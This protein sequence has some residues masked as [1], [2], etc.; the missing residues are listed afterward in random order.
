MYYNYNRIKLLQFRIHISAELLLL[1]KKVIY[2]FTSFAVFCLVFRVFRPS[3]AMHLVFFACLSFL[4]RVLRHLLGNWI[5]QTSVICKFPVE[6]DSV[7]DNAT[8]CNA[9]TG[10]LSQWSG[11]VAAGMPFSVRSDTQNARTEKDGE[12]A[13]HAWIIPM[14]GARIINSLKL[15]TR[16]G[17]FIT[18]TVN[19]TN[20]KAVP[21]WPS[22]DSISLTSSSCCWAI[23]SC[24]IASPSAT[25]VWHFSDM[26]TSSLSLVREEAIFIRQK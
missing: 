25:K 2:L 23:G 4:F 24:W 14:T 10:A 1:S 20:L 7:L 19:T 17:K 8:D 12:T 5:D 3:F 22:V 16:F 15:K 26:R 13:T 9:D 6:T 21:R 11:L 18:T